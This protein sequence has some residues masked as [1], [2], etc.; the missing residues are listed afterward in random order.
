MFLSDVLLKI[1]LISIFIILI[2]SLISHVVYFIFNN[3]DYVNLKKNRQLNSVNYINCHQDEVEN[4]PIKKI[5]IIYSKTR[6]TNKYNNFI[7]HYD[8]LLE[9]DQ[10]NKYLIYTTT[11][12]TRDLNIMYINNKDFK[13]RITNN[14]IKIND[15]IFYL[16]DSNYQIDVILKDFIELYTLNDCGYHI[17]YL[18]CHHKAKSLL[19]VLN[20]NKI[21]AIQKYNL[22]FCIKEL[23]KTFI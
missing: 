11:R 15:E 17:F 16:G 18:N 21:F 4:I 8:F 22:G 6:F 5:S 19:N 3:S 12:N 10:K 1:L 2:I 14:S 7:T 20:G 9:D 23:L 13:K